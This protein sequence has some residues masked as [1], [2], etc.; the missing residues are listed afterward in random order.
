MISP[1]AM[2]SD[3]GSPAGQSA[4]LSLGESVVDL[5]NSSCCEEKNSNKS[6]SMSLNSAE[7]IWDVYPFFKGSRLLSFVH[8]CLLL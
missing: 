3:R 2:L 8:G 7:L 4:F 5:L 1:C 6:V